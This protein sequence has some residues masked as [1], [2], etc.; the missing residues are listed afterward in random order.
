VPSA[1]SSWWSLRQASRREP[2]QGARAGLHVSD[3]DTNRSHRDYDA[4]TNDGRQQ[5]GPL[6]MIRI[7]SD[8]SIRLWPVHN[9]ARRRLD[10]SGASWLPC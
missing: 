9:E 7:H 3:C 4:G 8:H 5:F 6:L 2:H 10:E 1:A